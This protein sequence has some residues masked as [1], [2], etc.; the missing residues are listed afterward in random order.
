MGESILERYVLGGETW[1][2]DF[3]VVV[4]YHLSDIHLECLSALDTTGCRLGMIFFDLCIVKLDCYVT[5]CSSLFIL[6]V[7]NNNSH[8]GRK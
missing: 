7:D 5:L 8:M 2:H 1:L 4:V 6:I 3:E